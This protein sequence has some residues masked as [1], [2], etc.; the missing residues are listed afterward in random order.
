MHDSAS[1]RPAVPRLRVDRGSGPGDHCSLP[2]FSR[3]CVCCFGSVF[4]AGSPAGL[5][6]LECRWSFIWC[7][8][9]NALARKAASF[10]QSGKARRAAGGLYVEA[11]Q[12]A[13]LQRAAAQAAGLASHR[14]PIGSGTS[15]PAAHTSNPSL[16]DHLSTSANT[17]EGNPYAGLLSVSPPA[18]SQKGAVPALPERDGWGTAAFAASSLLQARTQRRAG[19]KRTPLPRRTIRRTC[20]V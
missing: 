13:P 12:Y 2:L 16:V 10:Q 6:R 14:N 4:C 8:Q 11:A 5:V 1:S 17:K 3:R 7:L 15:L 18:A 19:T 20:V 9:K